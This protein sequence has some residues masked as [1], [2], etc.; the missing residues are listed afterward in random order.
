MLRGR[1]QGERPV[2]RRARTRATHTRRAR[3][4]RARRAGN[5]TP[6]LLEAVLTGNKLAAAFGIDLGFPV[7]GRERPRAAG[8]RGTACALRCAGGCERC[9]GQ[10]SWAPRAHPGLACMQCRRTHLRAPA[11]AAENTAAIGAVH[12][13]G[14]DEAAVRATQGFIS[15]PLTPNLWR[16][17]FVN[18][19]DN[20][21]RGRGWAKKKGCLLPGSIFR[22]H[23]GAGGR[24]GSVASPPTCPPARPPRARSAAQVFW[25]FVPL[26][27]E[28]EYTDG[29]VAKLCDTIEEGGIQAPGACT[30]IADTGCAARQQR[31]RGAARTSGQ[32]DRPRPACARTS[33]FAVTPHSRPAA[34]TPAA[35]MT[36]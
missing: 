9:M 32:A 25:Q 24:S 26:K 20:Y 13:G 33:H 15:T 28:L 17:D 36:T 16:T 3:A 11:P 22:V 8:P 14:V 2:H 21:V 19:P 4:P 12:M 6:P 34:P 23:S 29:S 30:V 5:N 7:A 1:P 27:I 35:A 18:G 31:A 10:R